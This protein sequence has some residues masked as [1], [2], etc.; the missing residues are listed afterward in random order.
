MRVLGLPVRRVVAATRFGDAWPG[1]RD[2]FVAGPRGSVVEVLSRYS[3]RG[4]AGR[5][6]RRWTDLP[7]GRNLLAPKVLELTVPLPKCR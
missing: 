3:R 7:P 2:A 1:V 4:G 6:F 5:E